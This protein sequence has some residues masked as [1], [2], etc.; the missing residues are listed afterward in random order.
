MNRRRVLIE[1]SWNVKTE[2]V[3]VPVQEPERINRNIVECKVSI[4]YVILQSAQSI[5]RN[6]VECKVV[7]YLLLIVFVG[8]L[9]ETSWNVKGFL[10]GCVPRG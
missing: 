5:N 7:H 4:D 10:Q 6:I 9:I 1:T 3:A 2:Q 8:V